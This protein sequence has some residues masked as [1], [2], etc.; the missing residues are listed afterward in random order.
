MHESLTSFLRDTSAG[1]P[2]IW[3]LLI[4]VVVSIT[5]L[6]LYGF[7][8]LVL[9]LTLYRLSSRKNPEEGTR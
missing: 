7:W 8:E 1:N 9:R 5:S 3:A 2:I 6:V 4:M